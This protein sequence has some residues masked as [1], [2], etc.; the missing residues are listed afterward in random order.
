MTLLHHKSP[1]ENMITGQL[2]TGDVL[3]EAV[4]L[5]LEVT[6]R[7]DFLP[8]A[9]KGV[10]YVDEELELA[11]GRY[12]MQPLIWARL[13]KYAAIQKNETVMILGCLTGYSAAIVSH[14]AQKIVAIE[15]E[16][17]LAVQAKALLAGYENVAF[18]ES[19]LVKGA[20]RHAFDVI[21]IEGAIEELPQEISNQ[22]CEGGR[23]LTI[24]HR[25]DAKISGSGLG[26]L[27]QYTKI[28]GKLNKVTL[29]D[30]NC[31]ALPQFRKK[32]AFVF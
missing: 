32:L 19:V 5:A 10:A 12:Q 4:L 14:L 31:S 3:D 11:K 27:V 26:K 13:L 17:T 20:S 22:L 9:L 29:H 28:Q 1:V 7:A 30:A 8:D 6:Q 18:Q 23:I 24:E 2:M 16:K 15:E 21:I 25:F